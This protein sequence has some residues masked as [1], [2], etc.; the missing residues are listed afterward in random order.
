MDTYRSYVINYDLG[1]EI[2]GDYVER[3]GATMPQ[4]WERFIGILN[5]PVLP[6]DLIAR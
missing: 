5:S 3:G 2:V 4:R 1:Q 6:R